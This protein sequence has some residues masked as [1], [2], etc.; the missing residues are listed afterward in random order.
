MDANKFQYPRGSEWRKWD[1][2]VHT[3]ASFFWRGGK[4][5]KEMTDQEKD[6]SMGAFV[7]TVNDSDVDAFCIMDYWT[8]DWCHALK[9]YVQANPEEL[10]KTVFNGMELRVEC[11][12]DYRL[13]I[14]VILSDELSEQQL[15][16]FKSELK[17]RIGRDVKNLSDEALIN[18]AKSLD[19]DKAKVHGYGDP[20]SL[21]DDLLLKLGSQT[22]EVTKDSLIAAFKHIPEDFGFIVLPYDTS[23]GLLKLDWS[24]HPQSDNFFM[25]SAAIFESRDQRNIDL[26]NGRMTNENKRFFE[27]FYKTIGEKP[28][29][30]VSGSD[31]H[32]FKDYGIYPSDRITWIKA[33]PT[34]EGLKQVIYEPA[35]RV[36]IGKEPLVISRVRSNK[37]KYIRGLIMEPRTG[38]DGKNGTWFSGVNIE[39]NSEL[40]AIIGNKGSGKSAIADVLGLLGNTRNAGEGQKH[41]SFLSPRKFKKKGYAE[42][43]EGQLLWEDESCIVAKVPLS[44]TIDPTE[45]EKVRYLPQSYFESLTNELEINGFDQTLKSVTFLHIPEEERLGLATFDD[46]EKE[47]SK[48]VETD[49]LNL[50]NDVHVI[51]EKIIAL[52]KK[53][54]P[55]YRKTLQNEIEDKEKELVEHGKNKPKEVKDPSLKKSGVSDPEKDKKYSE[56]TNLNTQYKELDSSVEDAR[57]ALKKLTKEKEDLT[58]I[59]GEL[60]R[61]ETQ[62]S[63]YKS[64]NR[65]KFQQ[66]GLDI[67]Q[68]IKSEVNLSTVNDSLKD[69]NQAITNCQKALRTKSTIEQDES[70]TQDQ[71]D[72]AC[73]ESH[74][75]QQ[76]ILQGKIDKIKLDLN[77]PERD[78]QEYK[79]K[80]AVWEA[81]TKEIEGTKDTPKTLEYLKNIIAY[82]DGD[83]LTDLESLRSERLV[84]AVEIFNKKKEVVNLYNLFKQSIDAQLAQDKEFA[85]KFKMEIEAGFKLS[86]NFPSK[87]LGFINKAKLG[88][89]KGGE[90]RQV[91]EL[92]EEKDLLDE[93]EITTILK[94]IISSLEEDQRA[95]VKEDEKEREV[96]DQVDNPQE[97]YDFV[98][99]LD[100]LEQIYQL[101]LDEKVLDELSPGEKGAL[102]LVFY[103][104]I[105]KEDIP[106]VIDQPEDNLDNKSVFQVL[107]RFIKAAKKRRQIIIVTHN[108]NL[109]V[110]ADAEQIIYVELDKKDNHR[111]RYELGAIEHPE[112][113]N[114][115]V[116]ILEGTMP[117]FDNRKL[118]YRKVT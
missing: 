105:D 98:F 95:E 12:V 47:K 69:K 19:K 51:S 59:H 115:I 53:K 75:A 42:N 43:F 1:L 2:H 5:L 67:D 27:N 79:E 112:I 110:G 91:K 83:L 23:D 20:A 89:F 78:F 40:V 113:N 74:V 81:R 64:D 22:A 118:K 39:F 36:F 34:F 102:L 77:K 80:L 73:Q 6:Q 8:F 94:N 84:K 7:K 108:P 32:A 37:T 25:Q 28:K 63:T 46:L 86:N 9:K 66:L 14:H 31:A 17:I 96:I 45:T 41:L 48:N 104:I 44:Q 35:D 15:N 11:P 10:K 65:E 54:H 29:P 49:L 52:E 21:T 55:N 50:K 114:R 3:P 93:N 62:I 99:S 13:N 82:L 76:E 60:V 26:F 106:L 56:L 117:A 88:S 72:A 107:T 85:E 70:L 71:K 101:K 4:T 16:D 57:T 68:L 111:F 38:Y 33:D 103:L 116:E 61:F 97:F 18:F 24:K 92:F 100:Y 109:A 87:F 90:E 30:C 58:Q